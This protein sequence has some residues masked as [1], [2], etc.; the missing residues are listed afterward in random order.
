M[1]PDKA[2]VLAMSSTTMSLP[3][4]W[5]PML[6]WLVTLP[7]ASITS[8]GL[9]APS[10]TTVASNSM[11]WFSVSELVPASLPKSISAPSLTRV[12]V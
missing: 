2:P 12:S 1:L 5:K 4:L 9:G 3:A 11:V 6:I 8:S 7:S 10:M